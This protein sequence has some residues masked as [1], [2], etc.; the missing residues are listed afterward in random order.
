VLQRAGERFDYL[1]IHH[2]YGRRAMQGD[3]SKLVARPLHYEHFYDELGSFLQQRPPDRRP[4]LAINEWGLD[5]PES[6]QYS[7]VAALYGAR[8]M[9]VFERKSDL[10]A[11]SAV[12]DLVNGWPGGL[13][14]ASRQGVFVTPIYLVNALYASHVGAERLRLKIDDPSAS[15]IDAVASRSADGR[16]VYIKAVNTDLDHAATAR[17]RVTGTRVSSMA[18]VERVV[19]ESL[20]AANG[21]A[22][23]EAVNITRDT[24]EAGSSFSLELPRHSVVIVTLSVAN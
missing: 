22:T 23:P 2:Y 8:L 17:V 14:Q 3:L 18:A 11:M 16:S 6:Q 9:N 13:I 24:I 5:L 19:A 7:I 20:T 10:V 12:S 21:F 4:K 15:P 1:A